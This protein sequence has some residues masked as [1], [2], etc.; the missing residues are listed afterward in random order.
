VQIPVITSVEIG[1]AVNNPM[2]KVWNH[3]NLIYPEN[4]L[5]AQTEKGNTEATL[6]LT[7]NG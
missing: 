7:K 2:K 3:M 4:Q 6:D 1:R 5:I